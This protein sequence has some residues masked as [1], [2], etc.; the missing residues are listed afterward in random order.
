MW[1]KKTLI[2]PIIIEAL[3]SMPNDL[4]YNMKKLGISYNV[5]TLQ[6]YVILGTTNILIFLKCW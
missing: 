6:K 2:V 4:E 5:G 1:D 3:G